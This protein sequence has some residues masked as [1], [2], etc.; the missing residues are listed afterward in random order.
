ML[1]AL[2]KVNKFVPLLPGGMVIHFLHK[3]FKTTKGNRQS[4]K[5]DSTA[6]SGHSN[7]YEADKQNYI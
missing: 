6:L 2:T 7:I 5:R 3:L 1:K 4:E